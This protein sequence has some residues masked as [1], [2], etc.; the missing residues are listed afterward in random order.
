MEEK[1]SNVIGGSG[2][3]WVAEELAVTSTSGRV[4]SGWSDIRR[5]SSSVVELDVYINHTTLFAASN[6]D[7]HNRRRCVL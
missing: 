3:S 1:A 5:L 6:H 7:D 4:L 2:L